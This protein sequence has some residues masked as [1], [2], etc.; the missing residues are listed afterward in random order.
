MKDD[1][2]KLILE[3][4]SQ[5]DQVE[6]IPKE[7]IWQGVLQQKRKYA[8]IRRFKIISIAATILIISGALVWILTNW[9]PNKFSDETVIAAYMPEWAPQKDKYEKLID[10]KK[11]DL[12]F[13][14]LQARAHPEIF[15]EL[16]EL[17]RLYNASLEDLTVNE[18]REA[19]LK[20][21]IRYHERQLHLLER[22]SYEIQKKNEYEKSRQDPLVF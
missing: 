3:H 12:H 2:E 13:A 9:K 10:A 21:L 8:Q 14:S 22:L 18:N 16:K 1:F 5:L 20:I 7:A 15:T 4:R 19:I 17:D 6:D 11:S